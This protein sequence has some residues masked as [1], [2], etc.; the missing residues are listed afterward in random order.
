MG[1]DRGKQLFSSPHRLALL[2]EL[3]SQPA[4]TQSLTDAL[5][6]SRVTVQRHLN[7]CSKLGWIRKVDGRYELT[8]VGKHACEAAT[9]F[10]DRLSVLGEYED[11]VHTLAAV[12]DSFDPLLLAD[13]TI[14]V[15]EPSNPHE[16]IIHYRN[17]VTEAA[18][19]SIR[20]ILPVFSELLTEVHRDLLKSEVETELVVTQSVLEAAPPDA[21]DIPSDSFGLYVIDEPL[22]FGLTLFDE[23]AVVGTYDEGT[24]VSCI[25]STDPAFREWVVAVYEGYRERASRVPLEVTAD[26][27]CVV[28]SGS[29]SAE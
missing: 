27:D 20:G 19:D 12:D 5:S 7:R 29:D 6:I 28:Q 2:R 17:T 9:A 25:E 24:F 22:E 1:Y 13:A 10:L 21:T 8:P 11:I 3:R 16:P 14:S 26:P 18:T 15:A 4:D 23:T